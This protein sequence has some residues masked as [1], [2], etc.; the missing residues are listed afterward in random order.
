MYTILIQDSDNA[1][2]T[3][4]ERIMHRSSNVNTLQILVS[5]EYMSNVNG[6]LYDMRDFTCIM[7]YRTPISETYTPL[8]LNPS[9]ELYKGMIEYLLPFTTELTGEIGDLQVKFIFIKLDMDADGN[10]IERVRQI[11]ATNITILPVEKW[12]D[13]IADTNL[14]MIA[15]VMLT[16]QS[17][18]EQE[19]AY[20]E[21]IRTTK[22]DAL[23]IDKED[24]T[25]CLD[26]DGKSISKVDLK[27]LSDELTETNDT[28][29][30]KVII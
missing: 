6:T 10:T 12:S 8:T 29:T 14:D 20:A 27:E 5:P 18:I 13:Y 15:Q 7:E 25:L 24:Q 21:M 22:A 1:I 16:L 23:H 26:A 30:V 28:G 11:P 2:H 9:S 17:K 19:K 3:N 4:R